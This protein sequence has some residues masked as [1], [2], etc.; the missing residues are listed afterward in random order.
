MDFPSTNR[1]RD[2]EY[3]DRHPINADSAGARNRR[4]MLSQP[5]TI[6]A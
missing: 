4:D 1:G 5:A 2:S 6:P 3:L